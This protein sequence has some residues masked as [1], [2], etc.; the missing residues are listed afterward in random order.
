MSGIINF[1][2]LILITPGKV[3]NMMTPNKINKDTEA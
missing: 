1:L 3:D 2:C